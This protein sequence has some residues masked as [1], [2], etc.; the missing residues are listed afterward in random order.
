M[1]LFKAASMGYALPGRT[2]L[3]GES[4]GI[5]IP[6]QCKEV[7]MSTSPQPHRSRSASTVLLTLGG[8]FMLLAVIFSVALYFW[9]RSGL[10]YGENWNDL[11]AAGFIVHGGVPF[12]VIG[13]LLFVIGVV[14]RVRRK[15]ASKFA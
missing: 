15:A 4:I 3:P 12:F 6:G 2:A 13:L 5:W 1:T 10:P 8:V 9:G 7:T 14:L 11:K